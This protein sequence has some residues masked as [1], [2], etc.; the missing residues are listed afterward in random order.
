MPSSRGLHPGKAHLGTAG[1]PPMRRVL[2]SLFLLILAADGLAIAQISSG[3]SVRGIVRDEQGGVLP[4]VTISATSPSSIRPSMTVTDAQGGYRLID[5]QP[6][7]Y[8]LVAEL[9]GFTKSERRNLEI[10]TLS[11]IH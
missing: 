7:T 2:F 8:T 10:R 11:I 5:L 1:R 6:G 4:G 3:G 9:Q